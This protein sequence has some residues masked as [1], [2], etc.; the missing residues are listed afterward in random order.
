MEQMNV[1]PRKTNLILGPDFDTLKFHTFLILLRPWTT[2]T[3]V[4][5]VFVGSL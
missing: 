5:V 3:P 2:L 1:R 4:N